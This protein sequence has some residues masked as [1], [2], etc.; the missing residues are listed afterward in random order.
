MEQSVAPS[1]SGLFFS[2]LIS[3][4]RKYS[5]LIDIA[6]RFFIGFFET[7]PIFRQAQL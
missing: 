4:S 2:P 7:A 5:Y 1:G 6:H 3:S